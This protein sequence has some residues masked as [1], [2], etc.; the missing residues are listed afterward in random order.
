M[1]TY[2]NHFIAFTYHA[3]SF[4]SISVR[5][6]VS[7]P[8]KQMS[9]KF[10]NFFVVLRVLCTEITEKK[11]KDRKRKSRVIFYKIEKMFYLILMKN[12]SFNMK[13]EIRQFFTM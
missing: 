13:K 8:L 12:R 1:S 5:K 2:Q 3:F 9:H 10:L 11:E 6:E 4:L 7:I